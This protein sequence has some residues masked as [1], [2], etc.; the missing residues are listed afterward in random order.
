MVSVLQTRP[1]PNLQTPVWVQDA[2]EVVPYPGGSNANPANAVDPNAYNDSNLIV[3]GYS[4]GAD[5]ALMFA[6]KY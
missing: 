2:T 6:D 3:I 4:A 5:T 1:D